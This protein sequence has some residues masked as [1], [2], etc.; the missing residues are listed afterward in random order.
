MR[1]NWDKWQQEAVDYIDNRYNRVDLVNTTSFQRQSWLAW[2]AGEDA[3]MF[4]D[5]FI[6]GRHN[7]D[8]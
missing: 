1:S 7:E 2:S 8:R 5:D 6:R 4:I 3:L